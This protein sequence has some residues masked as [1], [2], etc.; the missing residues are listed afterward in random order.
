MAS[1]A[2][3]VRSVRHQERTLSR[4]ALAVLDEVNGL[5]LAEYPLAIVTKLGAR[6]MLQ[7]ALE[8]AIPLLYLHGLS[9]R[10]V[11]KA[12]GKLLGKRGLSKTTVVRLTQKLVETFQQWR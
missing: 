4:K 8:E 9:T 6:L 12:L 7:V 11:R 2:Q 10:R 5:A 3:T 1:V